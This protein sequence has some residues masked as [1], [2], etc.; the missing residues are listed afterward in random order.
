LKIQ[1]PAAAVRIEK[2][3]NIV[4]TLMF[5]TGLHASGFNGL[6]NRFWRVMP[7]DGFQWFSECFPSF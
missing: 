6:Y 7:P 3:R 1:V 5:S 2:N 4:K